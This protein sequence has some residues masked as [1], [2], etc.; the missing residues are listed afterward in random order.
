MRVYIAGKVTGLPI[1]EVYTKFGAAEFWL[2][3]QGYDVVN[4]LRLC[5]S[6]WSWERCMR[7][8]IGELAK[9]DVLCT[10]HDWHDSRGAQA[11]Y[12]VACTCGLRII[13]FR[14]QRIKKQDI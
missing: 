1:G 11:E 6:D 14:P 7:V 3:Q 4:P 5:S 9:C 2:K 12:F 10:L 8:C 13:N